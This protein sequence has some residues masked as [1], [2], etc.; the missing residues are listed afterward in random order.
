MGKVKEGHID[1]VMFVTIGQGHE[2][3]VGIDYMWESNVRKEQYW[4]GLA[5]SCSLPV[6]LNKVSL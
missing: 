5:K 1:K 2:R 3:N 6:F 4:P